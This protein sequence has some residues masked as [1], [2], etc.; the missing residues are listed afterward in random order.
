MIYPFSHKLYCFF[1]VVCSW[2]S[3]NIRVR[4]SEDGGAA[5]QPA[6]NIVNPDFQGGGAIVDETTGDILLFIEEGHSI[7]PV[8]LYRAQIM[9]NV[10]TRQHNYKAK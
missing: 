1:S 9:E 3:E 8:M 6:I 5:W 2:K 10:E 7:A 4:R